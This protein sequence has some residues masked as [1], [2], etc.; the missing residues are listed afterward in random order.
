MAM[1]LE[2]IRKVCAHYAKTLK[3]SFNHL[4]PAEHPFLIIDRDREP[5]LDQR[6]AAEH[7]L[8]MIERLDALIAEDRREKVMRWYGFLQGALWALGYCSVD[9]LK[10][11][12]NPDKEPPT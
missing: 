12:S 3:R 6:R 11:H 10:E 7:M 4:H 5:S 1:N 8:S 9:D 2:R